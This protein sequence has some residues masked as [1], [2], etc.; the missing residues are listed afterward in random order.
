MSHSRYRHLSRFD[1]AMRSV[2]GP[3]ARANV[4]AVAIFGATPG[5]RERIAF[6]PEVEPPFQAAT[7]GSDEATEAASVSTR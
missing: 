7:G 2:E 4:A 5:L 6:T 3:V 1:A